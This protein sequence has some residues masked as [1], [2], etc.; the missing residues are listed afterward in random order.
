MTYLSIVALAQSHS[1]NPGA[2]NR[3]AAWVARK[4][5]E[6]ENGRS[7]RPDRKSSVVLADKRGSD[8]RGVPA[9]N[10]V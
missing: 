8:A 6:A 2:W 10:R 5:C 3:L 1:D 7:Q 4:T 9:N